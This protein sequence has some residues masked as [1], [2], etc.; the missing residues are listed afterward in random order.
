VQK[1][2]V[3]KPFA[4]DVVLGE[5]VDV[6]LVKEKQ[7]MVKVGERAKGKRQARTKAKLKRTVGSNSLECKRPS[8]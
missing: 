3:Q 1:D 4:P 6:R 7:K 5:K 8:N 2:G